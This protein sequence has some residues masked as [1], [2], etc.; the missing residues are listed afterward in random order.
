M[1]NNYNEV[2]HNN[3]TIETQRLILR[4]FEGG[5]AEDVLQWASDEQVL[6]YLIWE[7]AFTLEQARAG[8]YDYHLSRPGIWAIQLKEGGKCIGCIDLRLIPEHEKTEFGY[9]LNRLYWDKGYATEA[10]SA[11][12]RLCFEKLELNRV[13]AG[14]FAGNEASGRVM[15]KAGMKKEGCFAKSQKIKGVFRD[16]VYYG[17]TK[18]DYFS[19]R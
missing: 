10:L 14:H 3:A 16:L 19:S 8:I 11:V 1:V 9:A 18:D 6:E 17:I 7:G 12:L 15:E 5:D 4:K 2:L 13:E